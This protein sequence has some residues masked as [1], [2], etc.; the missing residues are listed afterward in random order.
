[1]SRKRNTTRR[2]AEKSIFEFRITVLSNAT[3]GVPFPRHGAET[4]AFPKE[5]HRFPGH[6]MMGTRKRNTDRRVVEKNVLG[7]GITFVNESIPSATL[8]KQWGNTVR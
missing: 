4:Y 8:K 7:I 1:M 3:G 2:V 5:K 6:A